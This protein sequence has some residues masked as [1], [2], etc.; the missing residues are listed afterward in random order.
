VLTP[1]AE[2]VLA[3]V[4]R[5]L[6]VALSQGHDC[7]IQEAPLALDGVAGWSE[8][9]I[10]STSRHVMPVTALDGRRV[11]NGRVGPVTQRLAA[12]FEAYFRSQCG[13]P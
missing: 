5:D 2:Q 7:A 11:G 12:L 1:P 4:T 13:Y 9:F 8:A 3:G 6:L 10:T